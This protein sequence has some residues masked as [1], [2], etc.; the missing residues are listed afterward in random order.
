M[1]GKFIALP[2]SIVAT[3]LISAC[4]AHAGPP[5]FPDLSSYS[6]VNASDYTINLQ[7]T[8]GPSIDA[9]QFLTP[10]GITCAFGNPPS[11]GCTGNNLPA[12]TPQADGLVS[13]IGTNTRLRKSS[14][15]L[16]SPNEASKFRLLPPNHSIMVEGVICGVDDAG[17]TA[18]KDPQGHGFI[19]SPSWSGWLEHIA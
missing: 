18:C 6:P 17:M 8:G 1:I 13:S 12:L 4:V 2:W 9:V 11:A 19:L 14:T 5:T 15:P 16:A 3:V 10:D 7:N